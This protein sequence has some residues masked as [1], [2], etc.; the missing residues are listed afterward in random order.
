M[1]SKLRRSLVLVAWTATAVAIGAV[2]G[3]AGPLA[4]YAE[5]AAAAMSVV[6]LDRVKLDGAE[7]GEFAPYSKMGDFDARGHSFYTS[8]DGKLSIGVWEAT[9]GVLA[10]PDPYTGDELM[11]VLEGKIILT[12]ADGNAS[13]HMPG[14]GVVVPKGWSGTFSVPD[15]TR[16]IYVIYEPE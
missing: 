4:P 7:L 2:V 5:A 8:A 11:Y 13:T 6:E 16:K 10:I 9:P 15:G 14:D 3:Q 1:H 12:D